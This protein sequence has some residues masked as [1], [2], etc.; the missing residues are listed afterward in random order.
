[1]G[2]TE[3]FHLALTKPLFNLLIAIY[4]LLPGGDIGF[5][6]IALTVLI[7]L[8]LWP[9]THNSL[10]AQRFLQ[11]REPQPN[12]PKEQYKYNKEGRAKATM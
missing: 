4:N 1:M 10:K 2:I 5:A 9:L 6:I 7:K 11:D 12:A 3:L 8:V